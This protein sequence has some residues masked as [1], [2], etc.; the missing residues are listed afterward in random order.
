M[1]FF[2][3]IIC[4]Y[5]NLHSHVSIRCSIQA[6]FMKGV[7][8]R[9]LFIIIV[10][11]LLIVSLIMFQNLNNYM[12]EVL[13][14]RHS[15]RVIRN[16]QQVLSTIKDAEIG[17]RGFQ[18]TSD[19][20]YLE[21]YYSALSLLPARVKA[22]DSLVMGNKIHEENVDSLEVLIKNQFLIISNILS[23]TTQRTLRVNQQELD[24]LARGK[25]N[26][27]SI[28]KVVKNILD[29]EQRLF[30]IRSKTENSFKAIA[31]ITL[32]LYTLLAL[33]GVTF[34]FIKVLRG[35]S[36]HEVV[37]NSLKENLKKLQKEIGVRE[38]A[39]K[40]I[41][42][43][44]NNSLFE[45]MAFKS[46][47]NPT[48]KIE[49]FEW[50]LANDKSTRASNMLEHELIGNK[51]SELMPIMK[52]DL[53]HVFVTVVDTGVSE[54]FEKKLTSRGTSKWFYITVVKLEDGFVV[55]F[56]NITSQKLQ[57]GLIEE[58]KVI[59]DEAESLAQMGSWKWTIANDQLVWSHGLYK[60][61]SKNPGRAI[62]WNSFLENVVAEDVHIVQ[63]CLDKLKSNEN[64]SLI[65][66]RIIKNNRI[67]Y[68]SLTAKR[69]TSLGLDILGAVAD[70]TERK[71]YEKQLEKNNK[72]LKRSNE[73]LEEFA[74]VAS[75][76]LQE[77]LRKIRAFGDK[78]VSQYPTELGTE[79]S[80]Y[81]LRMQSASSRMQSLIQ[82]LLS[83]ATLSRGALDFELLDM[84][85]MLGDVLEDIDLQVRRGEATVEIGVIP[86][87]FGDKVQIRRLFQ[88][89]IA[90]AIKFQ[91]PTEKPFVKIQGKV[92]MESEIFKELDIS[93]PKGTY[94]SIS[95]KDNG[96]GFD[97]KYEE[98]IFN[99]FQRL[100]GRTAYA[101]TGIGLAIC[102]KIM[103]NHKGC[104]TAKSV[105]NVGSEFII[106]FQKNLLMI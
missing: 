87:V 99:I 75:H 86:S 28:R 106:I 48:G 72:E 6:P 43:I 70:I 104:I 40:T 89:L 65:E 37:E 74:Y 100:H 46:I 14:I 47:R 10:A 57:M 20:L 3:V 8:I 83:F 81:I 63:H 27:N 93:L 52:D 76:D 84:H 53:F 13:M 18:L 59:L 36:K 24:L 102:R 35:L 26:M 67:H 60:I 78:L 62:S 34:L 55:T 90:N 54:Q 29:E 91:K 66:Y 44:I 92:M 56:S 4:Q 9:P 11:V 88:N 103:T 85:S 12:Q 41:R 23:I 15:N 80:D 64:S 71:D 16:T 7:S 17:H 97:K 82:D 50:I 68:L 73:D 95:V 19:T 33:T 69:P 94:V 101:G 2:S 58:H 42:N 105:E 5:G 45:I 22:L 98:K 25:E 61:L 30:D 96:I 1:A 21:H 31:P 51:L 39:Q 38:F 49:D 32:L 77:P 79:G